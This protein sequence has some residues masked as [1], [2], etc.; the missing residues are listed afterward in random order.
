MSRGKTIPKPIILHLIENMFVIHHR[1]RLMHHSSPPDTLPATHRL[2]CAAG[3]HRDESDGLFDAEQQL[4]GALG[5]GEVELV[6]R[7]QLLQHQLQHLLVSAD[8]ATCLRA[9]QDVQ[10]LDKL[11]ARHVLPARSEQCQRSQGQSARPAAIL[12]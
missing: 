12:V 2:P 3:T 6:G 11:L 9:R 1:C 4:V 7:V 5:V 10:E 8:G